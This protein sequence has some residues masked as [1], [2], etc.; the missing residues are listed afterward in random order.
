MRIS[1]WSSDVCSSDLTSRV[2]EPCRLSPPALAASRPRTLRG[3]GAAA[4]TLRLP[5]RA[6][7]PAA[8]GA[9]GGRARLSRYRQRRQLSLDQPRLRAGLRG[10]A[11]RAARSGGDGRDRKSVVKGKSVSVRLDL[12]GRRTLKKKTKDNT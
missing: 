8:R 12:G 4:G 9:A 6:C 1:D 7:L 5:H 3:D 11:R 2:A 10:P